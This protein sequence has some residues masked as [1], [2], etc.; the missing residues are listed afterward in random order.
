MGYSSESGTVDCPGSS[1]YDCTRQFAGNIENYCELSEIDVGLA[2]QLYPHDPPPP[3]SRGS[4]K[5][6][7]TTPRLKPT[8]NCLYPTTLLPLVCPIQQK[9]CI[10]HTASTCCQL[11]SIV[12]V[13]RL[14]EINK[15][16][17]LVLKDAGLEVYVR[18]C[19]SIITKLDYFRQKQ[20]HTKH[21]ARH[22]QTNT[23]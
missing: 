3:N 17:A 11:H 9:S 18:N 21:A 14:R 7:Q 8:V 15:W 1:G 22:Y 5:G 23:D 2:W 12:Y 13:P 4:F 6:P 20:L 10:K 16:V 19:L